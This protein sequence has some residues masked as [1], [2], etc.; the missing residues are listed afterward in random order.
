MLR[1]TNVFDM[2]FADY[3]S[4]RRNPIGQASLWCSLRATIAAA[5][6]MEA[7]ECIFHKDT[8]NTEPSFWG[9]SSS[10]WGP[11][12]P[13]LCVLCT[14][15]RA[16]AIPWRNGVCRGRF[17]KLWPLQNRCRHPIAFSTQYSL[18]AER[19]FWGHAPSLWLART[20]RWCVSCSPLLILNS[21]DASSEDDTP[22]LEQKPF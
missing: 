9:H 7:L 15:P 12:T 13:L 8:T 2:P 6:A 16:D 4:R 3:S 19:N 18:A 5:K 14:I 11:K 17:E 22:S 20:L 10:W 21:F 1:G